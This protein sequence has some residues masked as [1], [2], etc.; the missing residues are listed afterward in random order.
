MAHENNNT[1]ADEI[2]FEMFGY[3]PSDVPAN[4]NIPNP[5]Q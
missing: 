3:Y 4:P 2:Y 1:E 5:P